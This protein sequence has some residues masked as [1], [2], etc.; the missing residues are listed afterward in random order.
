[1]NSNSR[2]SDYTSEIIYWLLKNDLLERAGLSILWAPSKKKRMGP[3]RI[4]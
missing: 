4:P 3:I 1:M 2:L